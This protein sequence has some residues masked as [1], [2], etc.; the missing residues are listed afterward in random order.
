[1]IRFRRTLT[2]YS[3]KLQNFGAYSLPGA[4]AHQIRGGQT[5]REDL[6]KLLSTQPPEIQG[7]AHKTEDVLYN[8]VVM[9]REPLP[10]YQKDR[11]VLVGDAA[12]PMATFQGQGGAQ[13]IED[14][15]VLG[16]LL[17]H[18]EDGSCIGERLRLYDDLRIRRTSIAQLVSR[19]PP[20]EQSSNQKMPSE[21]VELYPPNARP[22]YWSDAADW[23]WKYDCLHEATEALKRHNYANNKPS[24]PINMNGTGVVESAQR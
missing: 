9:D 15:A 16:V 22:V 8:W 17:G 5:R 3:N 2:S 14:G 20:D 23:M 18:M 19:V 24:S 7:L 11:L 12:H 6:I 1:M 10:S 21:L 13:S 4:G